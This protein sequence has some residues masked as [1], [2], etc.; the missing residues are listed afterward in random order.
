MV[1]LG[2]S[3]V[4]AAPLSFYIKK[5]N[6]YL[7][8]NFEMKYGGA[9][10]SQLIAELVNND[11][12]A[13]ADPKNI[14]TDTYDPVITGEIYRLNEAFLP[15]FRES[16]EDVVSRYG[17]KICHGAVLEKGFCYLFRL[18]ESVKSKIP[19][20]VYGYANPKSN[21]GRVDIL[22]RLLA[23]GVSRY[24]Y[25]PAGYTGS[26]W[27]M[28]IPRSF[29]AITHDGL[30]FNQVRFFNQDT[31]LDEMRLGLSFN[32]DGGFLCDRFGKMIQYED[33]EHSDRDGSILLTLG[34]DFSKIGFEAIDNGEPI[35]LSL[36]C[37]YDPR[38]FF[39]EIEIHNGSIKFRPHSFYILSTEESVRVKPE[40]TCEMR[41]MDERSGEIRV[42]YAGYIAPGWGVG[43]DGKG[44]G[45]PLTLE[46]R[47][48]ENAFMVRR[49]QP[50]AKIR[51]ERMI[52]PP[53]VHYD[54]QPNTKF[55]VQQGPGL[56]KYFKEW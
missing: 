18:V 4:V 47:S 20:G 30:S 54:Q 42:H 25:I 48:F 27:S 41:P 31:R 28:V 51:F 13:N 12:L 14:C 1:F 55:K 53:V 3:C 9:L 46:V 15:T 17:R 49:G 24:D 2:G 52:E 5:C 8:E 38:E 10:P 11:F 32:K 44:A 22:T 36:K 39:R 34:L 19:D 37:H 35:D 43:P 29:S 45:R 56:A 23:N 16:I 40:Y 50:F 26:L 6:L 7:E 33:V 21:I